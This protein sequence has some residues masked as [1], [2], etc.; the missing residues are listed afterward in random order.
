MN[1][2]AIEDLQGNPNAMVVC[3]NDLVREPDVMSRSIFA[4]CG[5]PVERQTV[6]FLHASTAPV[7]S[8]GYYQVFRSS[9]DALEKWRGELPVGDQALIP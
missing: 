9:T 5:L 8:S 2:K 1:D 4:F 3:Y 6:A 7:Q